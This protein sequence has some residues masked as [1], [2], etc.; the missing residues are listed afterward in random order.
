MYGVPGTRPR[1]SAELVKSGQVGMIFA[2][3]A[4]RLARN[5]LDWNVLIHYCALIG[6]VLGDESEVFDPAIPQDSLSLGIQAVLAVHELHGIRKRRGLLE[7]GWE[8]VRYRAD[9]A[10]RRLEAVD[11]ANRLV[12]D[13]LAK[14]WEEALEVLEEAASK[15]QAFDRQEPPRP[16][17]EQR[18]QLRELGRHLERVWFHP[19]CD[20]RLKKQIVRTLIEHVY[21]DV[22]EQTD[23]IVLWIKWA[24]GHLTELRHP[25]RR[26][27]P[28]SKPQELKAILSTFRKVADDEGIARILN[29]SRIRTERGDT[30]TKRRLTLF[31]NRHG[32]A[33]FSGT[34]WGGKA[35][36]CKRRPLPV[37]K[38]A[39]SAFIG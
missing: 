35:G 23:E 1:N 22:E 4:A 12:F 33:T 3:E 28:R 24:G 15:L 18:Q 13:T 31:R 29:R 21:A 20:G 30:W 39:P 10:R 32:I 25:R 16:T 7:D 37:W 17:A 14:E 19:D 38:S 36:C 8:H 11:P 9:L 2:F 6:V 27:K 34:E 26:R 5:N